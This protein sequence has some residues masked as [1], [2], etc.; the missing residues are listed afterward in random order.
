MDTEVLHQRLQQMLV[1]SIRGLHSND[2]SVILASAHLAQKITMGNDGLFVMIESFPE[3]LFA[4]SEVLEATNMVGQLFIRKLKIYQF[5]IMPSFDGCNPDLPPYL[6][7]EDMRIIANN[8]DENI[9]LLSVLSV[10]KNISFE[11]SNEG[12]IAASSILMPHLISLTLVCSRKS[13]AYQLASDILSNV[14]A[15]IDFIGRKRPYQDNY[16]C[17]ESFLTRLEDKKGKALM[18]LRLSNH[19]SSETFLDYKVACCALL[20]FCNSIVRYSDDRA[21]LQKCLEILVKISSN[22]DNMTV[23]QNM[24]DEFFEALVDLLPSTTFSVDPV[25]ILENS[26]TFGLVP[27]TTIKPPASIGQSFQEILDNPLKDVVIEFLFELCQSSKYIQEKL[28][29][30][31]KLY[32]L[33]FKIIDA[34]SDRMSKT[35][36]KVKK[37]EAILSIFALKT[38][39]FENFLGLEC[40]IVM[41]GT[42]DE[43]LSDILCSKTAFIFNRAQYNS[44]L[45]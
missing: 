21:Q 40:Q 45:N 15:K 7:T 38:S 9:L 43:I 17:P 10:L 28:S 27:L 6:I 14:S 30:N 32:E 35:D 11:T 3:I 4:L 41:G 25:H 19:Y 26:D 1:Q 5:A 33:L 34:R 24:S 23:L 2:P 39:N 16:Y 13:E 22:K 31:M 29:Q 20:S 18:T 36:E 12:Y 42:H 8:L 37:I 44:T